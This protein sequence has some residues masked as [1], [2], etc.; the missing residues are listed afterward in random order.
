MTPYQPPSGEPDLP[1]GILAALS[2]VGVLVFQAAPQPVPPWLLLCAVYLAIEGYQ[3]RRAHPVRADGRVFGGSGWVVLVAMVGV[4]DL[5]GV[6]LAAT[7][8]AVGAGVL[9]RLRHPERLAPWGRVL[10]QVPAVAV[11]GIV[12]AVMPS[13]LSPAWVVAIA[14]AVGG[15]VAHVLR[16]YLP[17]VAGSPFAGPP[18]G[19]A[20]ATAGVEMAGLGV[21]SA[22]LGHVLAAGGF[23]VPLVVAALVLVAAA[24]RLRCGLEAACRSTIDSLLLAVEAKD[25]YTRGHCQRVAA[26]SVELG[27][28]M[29]LRPDAV[30]RLETAALLHDFGKVATPRRLLRKPG[31]LSDDEYRLIQEHAVVVTDLLSGIEFLEQV[32][33][34]VGEHHHHFDGTAYGKGVPRRPQGIEARILAVSDAFDAMTTNRPYRQALGRDS[35]FAELRRC[36][37]TQFDPEVVESLIA[38]VERSARARSIPGAVPD[39]AGRTVAREM[40]ARG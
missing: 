3:L 11:A 28:E 30:D 14:G 13:D 35:A 15:T 32:L 10:G 5:S 26:L 34:I 19:P 6:V 17:I 7:I 18:G 21:A 39:A 37:G 33:P 1:L 12:A 27:R 24:D 16:R 38:V 9:H 22:L 36:A 4:L 8:P 2:S 40:A 20:W 31:R 25:L 23:G 29:G